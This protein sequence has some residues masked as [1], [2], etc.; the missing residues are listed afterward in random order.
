[1]ENLQYPC[2]REQG[3][4]FILFQGRTKKCILSIEFRPYLAWEPVT[5]TA[6]LAVTSVALMNSAWEGKGTE[7][8]LSESLCEP[9]NG[10]FILQWTM[11]IFAS[12]GFGRVA[13]GPMYMHLLFG[14]IVI[15]G[16]VMIRYGP[17][18]RLA[19]GELM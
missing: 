3:N 2:I 12:R 14:D 6:L 13:C 19:F 9:F 8:L 7:S 11:G 4:G 15:D 1:M 5:W 17:V 10:W 18:N 16:E